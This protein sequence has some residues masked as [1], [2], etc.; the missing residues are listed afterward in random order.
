MLVNVIRLHPVYEPGQ[1]EVSEERGLYLIRMGIAEEV[2]KEI[3]EIKNEKKEFKPTKEK[4]VR[5]RKK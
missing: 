5:K 2:E 4:V 3:V 1:H